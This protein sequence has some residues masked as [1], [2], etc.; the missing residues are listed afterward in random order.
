MGAERARAVAAVR[1]ARVVARALVVERALEV[2]VAE[3]EVESGRVGPDSS[4][5]PKRLQR[6]GQQ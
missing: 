2:V 4:R 3:T 5:R 6:S 1:A